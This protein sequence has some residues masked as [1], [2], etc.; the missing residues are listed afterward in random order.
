[1]VEWGDRGGF[2]LARIAGNILL[3]WVHY[4]LGAYAEA[5]RHATQAAGIA[6]GTDQATAQ[7]WLALIESVS[8]DAGAAAARYAE[9][10]RLLNPEDPFAY[11]SV[12]L[13]ECEWN[14]GQ[15]IFAEVITTLDSLTQIP[16]AA[17]PAC[18][19][20]ILLALK[21]EAL[22]GLNRQDEATAVL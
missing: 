17:V 2:Q 13:S 11:A 6:T 21:G 14:L 1:A 7:A 5:R 22:A 16:Q 15:G 4:E 12:V 9:A 18:F 20:P 3:G 19:R 8:G 10:R